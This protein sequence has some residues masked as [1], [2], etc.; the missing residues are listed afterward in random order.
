MLSVRHFTAKHK[1]TLPRVAPQEQA[2]NP[3][4]HKHIADLNSLTID[5]DSSLLLAPPP[6]VDY[7]QNMQNVRAAFQD[8]IQSLLSGW[9]FFPQ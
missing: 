4:Q 6:S 5:V 8:R 2:L 9:R 7:A 3:M 1:K